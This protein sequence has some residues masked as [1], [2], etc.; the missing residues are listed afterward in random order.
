MPAFESS[1]AAPAPETDDLAAVYARYAEPL[2]R[3]ILRRVSDPLVA[4]D[5][6]H[7][8]FVRMLTG[9]PQYQERGYP[10]SAWLYKIAACRAVDWLRGSDRRKTEV[11]NLATEA[12]S[13]GWPDGEQSAADREGERQML[14]TALDQLTERQAAVIR[15]RFVAELPNAEVAQRLGLTL[16]MVKSLQYRGLAALRRQL[17]TQGAYHSAEAA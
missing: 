4:E 10:I 15:L 2:Y 1:L 16:G 5:L 14:L 12:A 3:F 9:L 13:E 11:L 6:L 17:I 8:V 7:D